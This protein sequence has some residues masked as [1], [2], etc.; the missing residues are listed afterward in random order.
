MEGLNSRAFL[1]NDQN[2]SKNAIFVTS[3]EFIP[4]QLGSPNN[5]YSIHLVEF[6]LLDWSRGEVGP[7]NLNGGQ[8]D[9]SKLVCCLWIG[10]RVHPFFW[11]GSTNLTLFFNFCDYVIAA[12]AIDRDV[13][14]Q[15]DISNDSWWVIIC[16][17]ETRLRLSNLVKKL[18]PPHW[19]HV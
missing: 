16:G 10:S 19:D 7:S 17:I 13:I 5:F 15:S 11:I 1:K 6:N 9:C 14:G 18:C 3:L 4:L 8:R 2:L 12:Y